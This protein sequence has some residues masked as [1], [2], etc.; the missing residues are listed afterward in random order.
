MHVDKCL[1]IKNKI[2]FKTDS[3]NTKEIFC[4]AQIKAWV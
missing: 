1:D 2:I 4:L 3:E